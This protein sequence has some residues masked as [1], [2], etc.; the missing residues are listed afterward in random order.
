ME[1]R[2]VRP[3]RFRRASLPGMPDRRVQSPDRTLFRF[4]LSF[5]TM[6]LMQI[7]YIDAPPGLPQKKKHTLMKSVTDALEEAYRIRDTLVFIREHKVDSVSMNGIPQ[8]ENPKIKEI[9][10]EMA[11][12]EG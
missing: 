2:C 4:S 3:R 1:S 10:K 5:K 7:V 11:A 6:N 8:S 9:L 12:N